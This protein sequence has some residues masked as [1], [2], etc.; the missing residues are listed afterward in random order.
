MIKIKATRNSW[1][2]ETT[3]EGVNL[4]HSSRAGNKVVTTEFF[5]TEFVDLYNIILG[6]AQIHP[7]WLS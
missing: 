2:F 4:E 1:K 7:E 6:V 3:P 5:S